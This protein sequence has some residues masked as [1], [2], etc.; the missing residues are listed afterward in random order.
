QAA[1]F[2]RALLDKVDV[3]ELAGLDTS[4]LAEQTARAFAEIERRAP[5]E[6]KIAVRQATIGE[7]RAAILDIVHD[8]MPFLLDSVLGKLREMGLR[9]E[10]VAHP[11]FRVERG[12]GGELR[13]LE[14]AADD[15]RG[16]LR[17]SFI[18]MQLPHLDSEQAGEVRA[19]VASV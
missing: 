4:E 5:D 17:E 8:D 1:R 13:N 7:T 9:P 16:G 14:V 6:A 18:H 15:G 10:I 2:A 19:A 11:I 3:A 12:P